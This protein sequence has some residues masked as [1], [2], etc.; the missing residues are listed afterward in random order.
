MQ[1][2]KVQESVNAQTN[3]ILKMKESVFVFEGN[4]CVAIWIILLKPFKE[5]CEIIQSEEA[6]Y[7]MEMIGYQWKRDPAA[8]CMKSLVCG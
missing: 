8:H 5:L 6:S 1:F 3:M 7:A 2:Q 4:I